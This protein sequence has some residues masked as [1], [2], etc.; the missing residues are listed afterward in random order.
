MKVTKELENILI[1]HEL[2]RMIELLEEDCK[3]PIFQF[4]NYLSFMTDINNNTEYYARLDSFTDF[5]II[6]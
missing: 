5:I 4:D 6:N 3:I 1:K 2:D